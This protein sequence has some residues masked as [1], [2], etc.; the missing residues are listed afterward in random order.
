[1]LP[2]TPRRHKTSGDERNRTPIFRVQTA[3]SPIELHPQ[4]TTVGV[5]PTYDDLQSSASPLGHIVTAPSV[6][7]E[8]TTLPVETARS[9]PL[10]YEG[11]YTRLGSNQ[12]PFL[13]RRSALTVE[14][15]V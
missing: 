6:G 9:V 13:C 2:I 7:L 11:Q 14:L 5:E 4:K 10:S 1:V 15:R 8:P 12:Q 3:C